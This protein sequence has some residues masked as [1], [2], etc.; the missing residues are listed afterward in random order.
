MD[1]GEQA[2]LDGRVHEGFQAYE[3]RLA[4]PEIADHA[5]QVFRSFGMSAQQLEPFR[6]R[7]QNPA[8]KAILVYPEQGYG[9]AIF[10]SRFLLPLKQKKCTIL[11]KAQDRLESLFEASFAFCDY[12]SPDRPHQVDIQYISSLL[13]LPCHLGVKKYDRK[14]RYI[15]PPQHHPRA[16]LI[17]DGDDARRVGLCWRSNVGTELAHSKSIDLPTIL[18]EARRAEGG[19]RSAFYSFQLQ[20]TGQEREL[21]ATHGVHDL[22]PALDDFSDTAHFL[23]RMDRVITI[24]TAVAHL[25]AAIGTPTTVLLTNRRE[26]RWAHDDGHSRWYRHATVRQV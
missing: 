13:S 23:S 21:F 7:G 19:E 6:W 25:A 2:L 3:E 22:A 9:D 5:E 12:L 1:W 20:P 24:D 10:F 18:D 17:D 11:L 16:A 26:W 8:R 4:A 15:N 14:G